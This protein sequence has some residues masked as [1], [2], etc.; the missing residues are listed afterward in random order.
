MRPI[1]LDSPNTRW[2]VST[3]LVLS[4]SQ[5]SGRGPDPCCIRSYD[6]NGG[7]GEGSGSNDQT[8]SQAV[9]LP[10]LLSAHARPQLSPSL[11]MISYML[12]RPIEQRSGYVIGASTADDS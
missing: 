10:C 1:L 6:A 4:C 7:A 8:C 5:I 11:D 9:I 2:S 3:F 12:R